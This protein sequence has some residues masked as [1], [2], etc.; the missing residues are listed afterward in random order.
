M[1]SFSELQNAKPALWSAAADDWIKVAQEAERSAEHIYQRGTAKLAEHWSDAMGQRAKAG[2]EK[3][4]KEFEAA[5]IVV[6]AAA[7]TLDGFAEGLEIIQQNLKSA[8]AF[9]RGHG[10]TVHEDGRITDPA[11]RSDP[12]KA[13]YARQAAAQITDA[14][15]DANRLDQKAAAELNKVKAAVGATDPLKVRDTL[16]TEA[17][18][19]QLELIRAGLPM[20]ADP[21]TQAAWWNS[22]TPAQQAELKKAVPVE[23][24]DMQ[25]L[26]PELKKELAGPGY[27]R[28]EMIRWAR[29]NWNG[30]RLHG[31]ND[32]ANFVSNSLHYGGGL[33]ERQARWGIFDDDHWGQGERTGFGPLD[34]RTQ[35]D[36]WHGAN[37]QRDFMLKHGGKEV[38]LAGARPGDL[39]YWEQSGDSPDHKRG[40]V[41]HAAVVTSVTPDGDVHYTQHGPMRDASLN[42]RIP[43][44]HVHHGNARPVVVHL[45][46]DWAKK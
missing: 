30:P 10:L 17:S 38:G 1:V 25:G 22:M 26:P 6:R 12:A 43:F 41:Y 44:Q 14:L 40:E 35:S 5:A 42:G 37:A 19:N 13:A 15:N 2:M 39:I 33:G 3:L 27:N 32:C 11:E 4:G 46:P 20:D 9:A 16:L 21:R 34:Q 24:Y 23:L 18:Q 8:V 36:S 28:V 7:T 29:E 45:D 31:G